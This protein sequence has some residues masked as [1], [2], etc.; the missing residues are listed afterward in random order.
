[1]IGLRLAFVVI[2]FLFASVP[3]PDG[4]ARVYLQQ[5]SDGIDVFGGR[6]NFNIEPDNATLL[7]AG[8][9]DAVK[10]SPDVRLHEADPPGAPG[11][12]L[13]PRPG[14]TENESALQDHCG[15]SA[16]LDAYLLDRY[17]LACHLAELRKADFGAAATETGE[18]RNRDGVYIIETD[19]TILFHDNPADLEGRSLRFV[20]QGGGYT[21]T[22]EDSLYDTSIGTLVLSDASAPTFVQIDLV[23]FN[24]PLGSSS[25]STLWAG[26]D[27]SVRTDD[28]SAMPGISDYQY[29]EHTA[30]LGIDLLLDRTPRLAPLFHALRGNAGLWIW[31]SD[32]SERLLITWRRRDDATGEF[33]HLRRA[34]SS[35]WMSRRRSI[36]VERSSSPMES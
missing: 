19:D 26:T 36:R 28:G 21:V 35:T 6:A 30:A 7:H 11:P 29:G 17:R 9:P 12:P 33:F 2:V 14:F 18:V 15:T 25:F 32:T 4:G 16:E 1:M 10:A 23:N 22:E 20:P 5:V 24:F 27:L 13:Q 3:T 31:V 34:N 8:D